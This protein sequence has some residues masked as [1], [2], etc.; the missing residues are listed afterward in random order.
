LNTK[1]SQGSITRRLRCEGS[2]Y[3]ITAESASETILKIGQY[4]ANLCATAECPI[5]YRATL[6]ISAVFAVARCLSVCPSV[7]LVHCIHM[8]EDV[9]KL[10]CRPGSPI[11]LVFLTSSAGTQSYPLYFASPSAGTQNTRGWENLTIFN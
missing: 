10:L 3:A 6:C 4:W 5:F 11:I 8:A 2:R 7:T 1:V 9:V